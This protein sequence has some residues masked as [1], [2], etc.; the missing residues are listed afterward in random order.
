MGFKRKVEKSVSLLKESTFSSFQI[1]LFQDDDRLF[2]NTPKKKK[3]ANTEKSSKD[4]KNL[5]SSKEIQSKSSDFAQFH[6]DLWLKRR[7]AKL[8]LIMTRQRSKRDSR[9]KVVSLHG[10]AHQK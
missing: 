4:Q 2:K 10:S 8:D 3:T 1:M 9:P 5:K 7:E 6:E